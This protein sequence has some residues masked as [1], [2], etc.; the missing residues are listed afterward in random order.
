MIRKFNRSEM[1]L[2]ESH[3]LKDVINWRGTSENANNL[4]IS[5]NQVKTEKFKF[6]ERKEIVLSTARAGDKFLCEES[7]PWSWKWEP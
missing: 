7:Q 5:E 3:D 4:N 6:I 1:F 2:R